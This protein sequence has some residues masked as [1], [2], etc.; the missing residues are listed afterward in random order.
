VRLAQE[1]GVRLISGSELVGM[2]MDAG[3]SS[4]IG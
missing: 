4:I 2:L 3:F 1:R